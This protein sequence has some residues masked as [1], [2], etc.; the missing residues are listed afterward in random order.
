MPS[1]SSK[2]HRFME[3][4]A[5]NPQRA[6]ELK[7]PQSVGKDFVAADKGK[8]FK[9]GGMATKMFGGKESK[10]EET[11]EAKAVKSGKIS[12]SQYA[13]GEKSE[14][15]NGKALAK[16]KALKSGK[17]SIG[18]YTKG[19]NAGGMPTKKDMGNMG[20]EKGGKVKKFA[21]GGSIKPAP[22]KDDGASSAIKD[23][24]KTIEANK[25]KDYLSSEAKMREQRDAAPAKKFA[26]GGG[27]EV[28]GKTRGRII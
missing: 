2:Q 3:M 25:M 4:I 17:L 12:P 13:K 26:R 19:M 15:H 27:I 11:K 28:R 8:K 10:A 20:M 14:G 18:E 21:A 22:T 5:H 9:E 23:M 6:K 16:G 24:N 1:K 7:I